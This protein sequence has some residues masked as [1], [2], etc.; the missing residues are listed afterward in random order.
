MEVHQPRAVLLDL[1]AKKWQGRFLEAAK[2]GFDVVGYWTDLAEVVYIDATVWA[3]QNGQYW[4]I[5]AGYQSL[6]EGKQNDL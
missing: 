4:R 2:D 5:T 6:R 3:V 1:I